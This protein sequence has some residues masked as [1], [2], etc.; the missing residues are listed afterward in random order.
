MKLSKLNIITATTV[1]LGLSL[2]LFTAPV[3]AAKNG[4]GPRA[5]V[6]SATTCALDLDA[7]EGA[8]LVVTTTLTNTSSGS[9]I[10][11]ARDGTTIE[12][13][14]KPKNQRGNAYLSL[15]EFDIL[16]LPF[17]VDPELMFWAEFDLCGIDVDGK[18]DGSVRSEVANARELNGKSTVVYGISGGDGE[19]RTVSNRCTDD[20]DTWD[21]NE[22]GIYLADFIADIEAACKLL[23]P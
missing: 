20:P 9:V 3:S 12:G 10:S 17:D 6:N 11:E 2:A 19:E 14:Y 4:K 8:V 5:S 15:G 1:T 13:T 21:V 16:G 23:A 22:G 7:A 18:F